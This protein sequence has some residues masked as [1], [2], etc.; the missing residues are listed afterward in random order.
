HSRIE[1]LVE[2]LEEFENL[3]ARFEQSGP[4]AIIDSWTAHSSFANGRRLRIND[5]FREIEGVTRGLNPFGALRLET[6]DGKVEEVFSGDV[7][8]WK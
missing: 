3:L 7:I 4:A 5:G 6:P 2:F 1:L 8:S